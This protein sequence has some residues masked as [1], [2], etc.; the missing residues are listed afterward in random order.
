MAEAVEANPQGICIATWS[1]Q[2][3]FKG[4]ASHSLYFYSLLPEKPMCELSEIEGMNI[5]RRKDHFDDSYNLLRGE[6]LMPQ[7]HKILQLGT[8][9]GNIDT[10]AIVLE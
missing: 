2:P 8:V 3:H 7:Q 1:D 9:C 4:P 5:Q 10:K 6:H